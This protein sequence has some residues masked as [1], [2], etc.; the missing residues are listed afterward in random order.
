LKNSLADAFLKLLDVSTVKKGTPLLVHSNIG[1]LGLNNPIEQVDQA[2]KVMKSWSEVGALIFPAFT[3]SFGQNEVF[4]PKSNFN[5]NKM[6]IL[7]LKAFDMKFDRSL[8]PMF[9]LLG[10]GNKIENI[11]KIETNS[12]FGKSSTFYKLL[13]SDCFVVNI[14]SGAGTT[15]IH[16]IEFDLKVSYRFE[17]TFHGLIDFGNEN[18]FSVE[19]NSYVRNLQN[20]HSEANFTKLTAKVSS[21]NFYKRVSIGRSEITGYRISDMEN[22]LRGTL[23]SDPNFLTV[24]GQIEVN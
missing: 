23:I 12:S 20:K 4:R 3:Y 10:Y 14:G 11:F 6:G 22:F 19:W 1:F 8:D 24:G 2:L 13:Q 5:L 18:I 17:K 15:L 9:S 16:Q 21:M 7:S